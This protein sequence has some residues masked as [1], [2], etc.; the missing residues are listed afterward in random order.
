MYYFVIVSWLNK[1]KKVISGCYIA[2]N[3]LSQP[4]EIHLEQS[5]VDAWWAA[6]DQ[7]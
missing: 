6:R 1:H 3:L 4:R 5:R 2:G 7:S